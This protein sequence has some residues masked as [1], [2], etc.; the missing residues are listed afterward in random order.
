MK[1]GIDYFK[2]SFSFIHRGQANNLSLYSKFRQLAFSIKT[3]RRQPSRKQPLFSK[4]FSLTSASQSGRSLDDCVHKPLSYPH[5]TALPGLPLV[6]PSASGH[7][8]ILDALVC[9]YSSQGLPS[10]LCFARNMRAC[11]SLPN[12]ILLSLELPRLRNSCFPSSFHTQ[13]CWSLPTLALI[14]C[15]ALGSP[16]SSYSSRSFQT[17]SSCGCSR[18]FSYYPEADEPEGMFLYCTI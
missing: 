7:T 1:C 13:S 2:R 16:D 18:G 5:R 14:K 9:R 8:C 12:L 3:Q 4:L 10:F 6:C 11:S 15:D 17:M